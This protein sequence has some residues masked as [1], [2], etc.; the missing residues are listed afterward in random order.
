MNESRMNCLSIYKAL[1]RKQSAKNFK[2]NDHVKSRLR[3]SAT[4]YRALVEKTPEDSLAFEVLLIELWD[5]RLKLEGLS[6]LDDIDEINHA[7]YGRRLASGDKN[8]K[9]N[10]FYDMWD[11]WI[12]SNDVEFDNSLEEQVCRDVGLGL[13]YEETA[14]EIRKRFKR[15]F[16]KDR[17][18]DVVKK[19][20]IRFD[21][22]GIKG[23]KFE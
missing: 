10:E 23:K 6:S 17:V 16:N 19:Y 12:V 8:H 2:A 13:T 4:K 22:P 21:I 20:C 18:G 1:I 9:K 7:D 14:K 15:K 3:K 11:L 5:L